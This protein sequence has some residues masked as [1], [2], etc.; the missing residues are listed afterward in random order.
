MS[1]SYCIGCFSAAHTGHICKDLASCWILHLD[2]LAVVG[3]NPV[4]S[5][6]AARPEQPRRPDLLHRR[7]RV[8]AHVA[9]PD[10]AGGGGGEDV[11]RAERRRASHRHRHLEARWVCPDNNSNCPG[12]VFQVRAMRFNAES[13]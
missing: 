5:D 2:G 4:A 8:H 9:A 6:E 3:V 7:A 13:G 11:A 1:G 12:G 10:D